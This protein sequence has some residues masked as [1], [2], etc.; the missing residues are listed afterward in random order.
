MTMHLVSTRQEGV[1]SSFD[2]NPP[3]QSRNATLLGDTSTQSPHAILYLVESDKAGEST[4][5]AH[6]S[7]EQPVNPHTNDECT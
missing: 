1:E 7:P 5:Q 2:F 3:R 6:K 4:I